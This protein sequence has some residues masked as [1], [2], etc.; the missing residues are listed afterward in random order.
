MSN[1]YPLEK[2][3]LYRI[4][5]RKKLAVLLGLPEEYFCISHEYQYKCFTKPKP[6]GGERHFAIPPEELKE[7]QKRLC[8]LLFRIETLAWVISGKKHHSYITNAE[9][10]IESPFVKTMDISQFY[11]SV[12]RGKIYALFRDIFQMENDI[13]W[14]MT[15][16][17][18]YNG[19]LPTG[20][21]TSQLVVYWT[22][23]KMF[24]QI[25]KIALQNNCVF[26]LYVDDMTF[27]SMIPIPKK[28]REDVAVLLKKNG[29]SAKL[30]KDHYYQS[31]V[32][33]MVTGVGIYN[34]KL[35]IPNSKK[36]QILDKYKECKATH[37]IYEI[38]KLN[39]MLCS[40]RQIDSNVFPEIYNFIKHFDK[41]LK[42]MAKN[43]YYRNR[44]R[45]IYS[46]IKN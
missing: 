33:K 30:K 23:S 35:K 39:G 11:D 46:C 19:V 1:L 45:K 18:T 10:H 8:K 17:V 42:E 14:L 16:L 31:D 43:R 7:I 21:P 22:Y 3:P 34:G 4:R 37:N 27:S 20:S 5:N 25:R 26:T 28:L 44:K 24:E 29:L 38:E 36:K 41:E 13:C 15:E 6:G 9:R 2:S 12:Q 40:L 32:F